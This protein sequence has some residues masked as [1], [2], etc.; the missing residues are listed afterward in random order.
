[1]GRQQ[2]VHPP[3]KPHLR[4]RVV[5]CPETRRDGVVAE[6]R[7][8]VAVGLRSTGTASVGVVPGTVV[9]TP[10]CLHESLF[11]TAPAT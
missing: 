1:M 5:E 6:K 2:V 10:H 3:L 8:D 7:L 9:S 4:D 11:F